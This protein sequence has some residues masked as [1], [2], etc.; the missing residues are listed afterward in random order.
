MATNARE[1]ALFLH[2]LANGRV[3]GKDAFEAMKSF[4]ECA[5]PDTPEINGV[6]LGLFRFSLNGREYWG[7]EGL[8]IGSQSIA[9]HCAETGMTMAVIGNAS[10]FDVVRIARAIDNAVSEPPS[11]QNP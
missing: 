3:L 2:A 9:L 4:S 1:L 8:M 11:R 7:H 5:M 10:R 6:G